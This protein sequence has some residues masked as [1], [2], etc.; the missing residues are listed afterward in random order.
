MIRLSKQIRKGR[1]KAPKKATRQ[2]QAAL[3][4]GPHNSYAV[5]DSWQSVDQV[6]SINVA[7]AVGRT[8]VFSA[9]A[10]LLAT[11]PQIT[12]PIAVNGS[13]QWRQRVQIHA[14]E[15]Y[16]AWTG[17]QGTALLA[18]DLYNF[19]RILL[20]ETRDNY[21]V[22]NTTEPLNGVHLPLN[23]VDSRRIFY[24]K[25]V[26]LPSHAFN[27][28][29]YNVPG[30]S[31]ER[32]IIVVNQTYDWF[33]VVSGAATGWD[34]KS[35]NIFVSYVSDSTANPHPVLNF[36]VRIYFRLLKAGSNSNAGQ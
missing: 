33:T 13:V 7:S 20:W 9:I 22:A 15:F 2:G 14:L 26:T 3:F 28:G 10:T 27:A 11:V 23:L 18:G 19:G 34:T 30:L 6:N 16:N 21:S 35:G 5:N 25:V 4:L 36:S 17:S 24:D 29:D 31:S 12:S 32:C 8:S 1:K